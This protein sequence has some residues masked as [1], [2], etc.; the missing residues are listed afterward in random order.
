MINIA[1]DGPG[2]SGKSSLAKRISKAL[3]LLYLDTGALY[4][5]IG[6]TALER[7]GRTDDEALVTDLLSSLTVD[8]TYVDGVQ[9]VSVNGKDVSEFIRTQPV[10]KAAS[11][12]SAYP[13]VRAFLLDLQRDL[14]AR[15]DVIMDG[16]DVGT[17]ILPNA[18]VKIFLTADPRV[19]AQ[20]R[21]GELRE[22]GIE[23]DLETVLREIE[24]RDR[25]DATRAIAPLRQAE[26]AVLLDNSFINAEQTMEKALEIIRSKVSL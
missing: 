15:N 8:L 11:A 6:Y 22:K 7:L 10:A 18:D 5:A 23:A 21:V 4:R 25:N 26:D 19:R 20:R 12:V 17:V 24:E 14:A 2:G 9:H 1:V 16:R 13:A 3:G